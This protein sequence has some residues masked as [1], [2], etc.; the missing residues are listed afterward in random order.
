MTIK[1][2][3]NEEKLQIN[4]QQL[5]VGTK[6]INIEAETIL[7][8]IEDFEGHDELFMIESTL[9]RIIR[10]ADDLKEVVRRCYDY[11]EEE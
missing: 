10:K 1:E 3:T 8:D 11:L 9:D 2:M 7:Q 4:L 5:I 6:D